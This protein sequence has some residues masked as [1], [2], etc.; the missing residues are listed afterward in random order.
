[1][2][3]MGYTY[4]N[5]TDEQTMLAGHCA[6]QYILVMTMIS[7]LRLSAFSTSHTPSPFTLDIPHT[8]FNRHPEVIL[9]L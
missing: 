2:D 3:W 1:M 4:H 6:Q 5:K 8:H 9:I 7:V